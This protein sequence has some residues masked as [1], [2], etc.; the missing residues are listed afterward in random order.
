MYQAWPRLGGEAGGGQN[1]Q[2]VV[3]TRGQRDLGAVEEAM[4]GGSVQ[5]EGRSQAQ[6]PV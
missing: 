1:N 4:G 5:L 6:G 2:R 3:S